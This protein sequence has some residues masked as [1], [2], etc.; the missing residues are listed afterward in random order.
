MIEQIL[1]YDILGLITVQTYLIIALIDLVLCAAFDKKN[2]SAIKL[3]CQSLIWPWNVIVLCIGA[4]I[5]VLVFLF[6]VI[7]KMCK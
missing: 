6:A 4:I 1:S 3:L 2:K 5:V 7:R